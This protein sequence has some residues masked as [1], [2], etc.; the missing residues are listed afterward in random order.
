LP[1]GVFRLLHS[2]D[3]QLGARFTQFGPRAPALRDARLRTLARTLSLARDRGADAFLVAGDLFEDNEVE[4]RLVEAALAVFRDHPDVPIFVLPGNHDPLHGPG[5][6]WQRRA[7]RQPPPHVT[8]LREPGV[9]RLADGV[10]LL[11]S[12]LTQKRSPTDPSLALMDLARGLPAEDLK[13]GVTHGSPA[14]EARHE[15]DD[16]P[17][18][19]RAAS[20]AGLDYLALGHW[21]GWLADLDGGRMVMPGTPEPDRFESDGAGLVAW[22]ELDGPGALPRV[23]PLPVAELVWRSFTV[24][25]LQLEAARASLA[26]ELAA[27]TAHPARVVVRVT[28]SGGASPAALTELRAWLDP[29][30]SAFLAPQVHDRTRAQLSAVELAD[31]QAR[32]PILNAVLADID[33]LEVFAGGAGAATP[34][35]GSAPPLTLKEAQALLAAADIDLTLLDAALFNHLRHLLLQ[36]LQEATR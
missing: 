24:D 4:D 11:A 13:I 6:V 18:S 12:P 26:G 16:F 17:I 35:D 14:I 3:W 20:R 19:L 9:I 7:W 28:L 32:H 36:A 25:C 2:A 15:P 33:R 23:E 21:H 8:V 22:V 34:P 27:L 29:Q 1:S 30:L 5:S 31:L 10:H